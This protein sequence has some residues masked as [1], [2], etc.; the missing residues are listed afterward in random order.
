MAFLPTNASQ[1]QQFAV[2]L[3]GIQ[4]GT[5][6][7]AAVQQDITNV[8][9]LNK[10]LNA[11]YAASFGSST[12]AAVAASVVA[13]LGLTGTAATD[14]AAYITAVLNGTAASARGEAILSVLN[15]FSTLTSNATFGTAATAW[16]TKVAAAVAY[17]GAADAAVGSAIPGTTFAL[18]TGVDVLTGTAGNDTFTAA[19]GASNA[20]TFTA[21]D[22][23]N[24]G[25]GVDTLNV[26]EIGA[27][28]AGAYTLNAAATLKSVEVLNYT[29]SSDNVGDT[30][31]ADISDIAGL[32]SASF[33]IAGTD[34][35][36]ALDT[37]GNV[38]SITLVG[39]DSDLDVGTGVDIADG[40][41]TD[42]LATISLTSMSDSDAT[43]ADAVT[44]ASDALTTMSLSKTAVGATI[45]A[46]AATRA[47]TLN[48]DDVT[49]GTVTDAEATSLTVNS[50]GTKSSGVTLAAAKATGVTVN[51]AVA[52]TIADV[53]IAAA[54]TL[55]VTGAGATTV[56]AT[57]T[58][59]ALTSVDATA[60]T[61]GL[62]VTAAL[63]TGVTFTGGAG[64]DSVK[65][66]ATT[67]AITTGAG[68]DK[69]TLNAV[70]ALGTGGSVDAGEGTDTLVF[71]TYANAVTASGAT[72]FEGTVSGFERLELSGVN[73]AAAAAVDL[74]NLDDINYVTLSATNT[75][76]TT[77]SN[78]GANGTIAFK[79]SQTTAKPVTVGLKDNVGSSDV[80][81]VVLSKDTATA[82][83][84]L[85]AA[86]VE[87]IN[88]TSTETATTLLGTVTHGV[89]ALVIADATALNISGNAGVT[90]TTLTGT[91][92]AS[93]D[94][95]GV[96]TGLVSFTTGALTTAAAIKGGAGA[97]TIVASAAT[98]AVTYTGQDKVDT[99]TIDNALNNVV[100]T[101]GGADVI[102]TGS[103]ADT[104]N[105]GA[106]DDTI[107]SGTGLDIISGGAGNDTFNIVAPTNGNTYV[108]ITDINAGDII[109][110]ANQGTETFA[111]AKIA[112]ADTALF[113]DYLA[114]AT[115]ATNAAANGNYTWFQFGGNTYLVQ[116]NSD[117]ATFANGTDIIV[118]LSGLVDLS[119]ATGG[120][121]NAI[122]IA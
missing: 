60:S 7:M 73:A 42:T 76:T 114:A 89:E 29:V 51:A 54:K 47:L 83:V 63:G 31:T 121:T 11:Y 1:V 82:L 49:G 34:A 95:S 72:T 43:T 30:L 91:K 115:A 21:L 50:S 48:L 52:T 33:V 71:S 78:F 110:V 16:N 14:A 96:S 39:G 85:T 103:G 61:G 36:M 68:D 70:A 107:T 53:T 25:D 44:I 57:T 8:G 69:V 19:P 40:A 112:L 120:T 45:T 27:A 15:L 9:G 86:S 87:T 17:T 58:V 92:L 102:V 75:E 67:K 23:I 12:T 64:K 113:A 6:T 101:A 10:A 20:N 98:K 13:N 80:L 38:A 97:N 79:A 28:G 32:T 24:G 93:I 65:L 62:T 26:T 22:N 88:V 104:I 2:A 84:G 109:S 81:N 59:T 41:T 99:I 55:T 4:V 94:A 3:Y 108:T 56:T 106:G 105:A 46:A 66:G 37:K 35:A 118:K 90:I 74:A 77:I 116:D 117:T 5:A 119:T 122:T 111:T 100:S 18:S